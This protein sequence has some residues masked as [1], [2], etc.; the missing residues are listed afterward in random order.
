M[1]WVARR[2]VLSVVLQTVQVLVT[3]ATDFTAIRLLLLHTDSA[4]VGDRCCGINYGEAAIGVF[5]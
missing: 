1:V 4:G 3:L 2:R 5:L